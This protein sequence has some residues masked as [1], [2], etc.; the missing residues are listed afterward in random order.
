MVH[1]DVKKVGVIPDGG[2]WRVHGRGSE[3]AKQSVRGRKRGGRAR[4]TYLHTAIDG[5]SRLAYTEALPDEKARTAIG[6][7]HRARA[8]FARHGITH[9]HRIVTD[10]QAWWRPWGSRWHGRPCEDPGCR[11]PL[12]VLLDRLGLVPLAC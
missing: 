2:G 11:R 7:T 3:Q 12:A 5:Y 4:Y 10:I 8:F 1:L 9:I 6:F